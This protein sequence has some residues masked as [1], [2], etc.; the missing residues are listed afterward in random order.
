MEKI[1]SHH[2]VPVELLSDRGAAF[3]SHLLKEV[4]GLLGIHQ[5]NTTSY[6]PQT[7]G[8]VERFNRTLTDMLAK[9]VDKSGRD[10]DSHLPYVLFAYRTSRQEWT[11]ES[12]FFQLYGH[13][14][15]L[16]TELRIDTPVTRMEY[17]LD[18]Y[19]GEVATR[20]QK[21]WQ[22]AQDQVKKA[23]K[24]QKLTLDRQARQ[25]TYSVGE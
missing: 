11:G 3:L 4:C 25:P 21:A 22:L 23:Q 20:L 2:G 19:K 7:D 18:T 13:D 5:L 15:R 16:P 8:L 10:W 24:R 1:I 9:R 17:N 6:H 14:P 12:R